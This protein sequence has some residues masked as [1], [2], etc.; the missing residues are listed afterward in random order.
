M[1]ARFVVVIEKRS[2]N[3]KIVRCAQDDKRNRN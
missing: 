3:F 2:P 1:G